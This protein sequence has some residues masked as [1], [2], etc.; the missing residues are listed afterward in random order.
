MSIEAIGTASADEKYVHA[1]ALVYGR[2]T[3]LRSSLPRKAVIALLIMDIFPDERG[4]R[5]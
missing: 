3:D 2:P 4:I 5:V 1:V